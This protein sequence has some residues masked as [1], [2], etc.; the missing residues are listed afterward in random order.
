[1]D[2]V[3]R[4]RECVLEP[5]RTALRIGAAM[6]ATAEE[7]ND[8]VISDS[9][10]AVSRYH[11]SIVRE[12]DRLYLI[13]SSTNG[14]AVNGRW[15]TRGVRAELADGDVILITDVAQLQLSLS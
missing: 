10:A 2:G 6:G 15:L 13:D 8:L 4:G 5:D 14:T 1:V 12:G 9:G 3:G 11:C 7:Q